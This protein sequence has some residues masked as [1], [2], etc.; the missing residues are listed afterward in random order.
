MKDKSECKYC[1]NALCL[2]NKYAS[3]EICKEISNNKNQSLYKKGENIIKIGL[4][5]FGI[6]IIM[7][8]AVKVITVSHYNKQTAIRLAKNGSFI[9][10]TVLGNN[11]YHYNVIAIKDTS[12]CFIEKTI[13]ET[14]CHE[15][16][17]FTF[18]FLKIFAKEMFSI[19]FRMKYISLMNVREKVAEA[20]LY[21]IN[22]FGIDEKTKILNIPISRLDIAQLAG[23]TTEQ[24]TRQLSYFE[25]EKLISKYNRE[26]HILD[27]SGLK[28]IVSDYHLDN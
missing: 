7:E 8:G 22:V 26:I 25:D 21:A 11:K 4:P 20:F 3:T 28:E 27:I 1:D 19:R 18:D 16:A 9:G 6:F 24:V 17:E 13:F 5:V 14:V 2:F 10:Y 23:T 12:V 15:N